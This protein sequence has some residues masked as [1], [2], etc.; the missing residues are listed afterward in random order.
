MFSPRLVRTVRRAGAAAL[1]AA[2]L[3]APLRAQSPAAA[4]P[5]P[6]APHAGP[7]AGP[8][9]PPAA[10]AADPTMGVHGMLVAGGDPDG[11]VLL[12]HLPLYRPP[13]DRQ[14]LVVARLG[15]PA[16]ARYAADRARSGERVYT[17]EP[18]RFPLARLARAGAGG[19]V[20]FRATLYRGHFERGG[21][22]IARDVDVAVER[23]LVSRPVEATP[24]AAAAGGSGY[25]GYLLRLGDD[26]LLAHRVGGAPSYDQV[27][28]LAPERAA[29]AGAAHPLLRAARDG[30]V[31]VAVLPDGAARGDGPLAEGAAVRLAAADA[32]PGAG[33]PPALRAR[34]RRQLSLEHDDLAPPRPAAPR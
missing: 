11:R 22:P 23:V 1:A 24:A 6:A 21:T 33:A 31:E 32:A 8:H 4:P 9:A 34:V 7:H 13:H 2:A 19:G 29:G 18:E 25:P 12:S 14:L 10:A 16:A 17:I 15:G 26:V 20:R 5:P 30:A 28:V 27:L 3:A